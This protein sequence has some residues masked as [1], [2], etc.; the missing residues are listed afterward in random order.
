MGEYPDAL[1]SLVK[2][3]QGM[4]LQAQDRG[5]YFFS[6]FAVAFNGQKDVHLHA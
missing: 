1:H 3:V 4:P 5:Q 2:C 6:G